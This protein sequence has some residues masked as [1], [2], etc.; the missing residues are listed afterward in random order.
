MPFR[1]KNA[2][3]TFQRL[4]NKVLTSLESCGVYLDNVVIYS[5]TWPQHV[6]RLG[7]CLDQLDKASFTKVLTKCKF[8][9]ATATYLGKVVGQWAVRLGSSSSTG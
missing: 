3:S 8:T 5:D 6:H 7:A 9:E 4:M 2:P 1:L